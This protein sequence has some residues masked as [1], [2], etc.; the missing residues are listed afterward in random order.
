MAGALQASRVGAKLETRGDQL[1]N[2]PVLL[3]ELKAA[4]IAKGHSFSVSALHRF[5][6]R[7]NITFKKR[8]RTPPSRS[9]PTSLLPGS[10]GAS[11]SPN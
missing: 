8:Q 3:E 4:L 2:V 5:F 10:P 11:S 6:A 1:D 7:R 9:A